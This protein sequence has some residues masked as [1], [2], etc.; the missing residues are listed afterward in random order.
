MNH[1]I[2]CM[3]D[4]LNLRRHAKR[5]G[6]ADGRFHF[7]HYMDSM[8]EE[9]AETHHIAHHDF[10]DRFLSDL[11][12]TINHSDRGRL[13]GIYDAAYITAMANPHAIIDAEPSKIFLEYCEQ[14]RT[15][16]DYLETC[17]RY[18]NEATEFDNAML[19]AQD[20]A[21]EAAHDKWQGIT[22]FSALH[23]WRCANPFN[24]PR[25]QYTMDHYLKAFQETYD[26]RLATLKRRHKKAQTL[27]S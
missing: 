10:E 11:G 17:K 20:S 4:L 8:R 1:N 25:D 12:I 23:Y 19:H 16:P 14:S 24:T 15:N 22:P 3:T 9:Q 26:W 21:M 27:A 13:R 6:I 2:N 7:K 5:M 18:L